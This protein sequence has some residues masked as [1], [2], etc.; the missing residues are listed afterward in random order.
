M[1]GSKGKGSKDGKGKKKNRRTNDEEYV[2]GKTGANTI[3]VNW[4]PPGKDE[5]EE[6]EEANEHDGDV[7]FVEDDQEIE[8]R[9]PAGRGRDS[10]V[11]AWM[12]QGIGQTPTAAID[13]APSID[14]ASL[15]P[16]EGAKA[17]KSSPNLE[18]FFE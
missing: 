1:G 15:N 4:Q 13:S 9:G 16:A 8:K 5:E 3:E 12:K 11:P 14:V 10:T 7:R 18:D 6:G 17:T 2:D